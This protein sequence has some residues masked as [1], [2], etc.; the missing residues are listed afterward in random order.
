MATRLGTPAVFMVIALS[1]ASCTRGGDGGGKSSDPHAAPSATPSEP[2]WAANADEVTRFADEEPF[3]PTA[4]VIADK[5]RAGSAPGGGD[6]VATLAAGTDVT[7]LAAH[8][9]D[10]L[11]CFDEP[12]PGSRHLI[13]WVAQSALQ[14]PPPP[15]PTPPDD[16]DGGTPPAPP[17]PPPHKGGHH[18]RPHKGRHP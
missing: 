8:G 6:V 11:V 1:V 13:G 5:T 16:E 9:K 15:A 17:D 14:D 4:T 12:K 10:D 7:K 3:G 18:H 2:S